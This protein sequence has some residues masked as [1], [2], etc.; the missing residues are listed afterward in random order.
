MVFLLKS[1]NFRVVDGTPSLINILRLRFCEV[2]GNTCTF[3]RIWRTRN[4]H[5][6]LKHYADV[7]YSPEHRHW[8]VGTFSALKPPGAIPPL[9]SFIGNDKVYS[10]D[11]RAHRPD[12]HGAPADI[13]SFKIDPFYD[14]LPAQD[15]AIRQALPGCLALRV[16]DWGHVS[17][18][19]ESEK[20]I[21]KLKRTVPLPHRVGGMTY[22]LEVKGDRKAT[23]RRG[24][25]EGFA[26][27]VWNCVP[28][29][30]W[31]IEE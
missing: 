12:A 28:K 27:A 29:F 1:N 5:E 21:D 31:S 6:A 10:H 15:A 19:F 16:H 9:P 14:L 22:S 18:F 23:T 11:A 25:F 13:I 4:T 20:S 3:E 30:S 2:T 26:C 24:C 8:L 7:Y 17:L